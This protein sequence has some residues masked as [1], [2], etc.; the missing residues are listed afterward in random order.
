MYTDPSGLT[1]NNPDM[2]EG[3]LIH[4]MIQDE[5]IIWG[6][7]NGK[8]VGIEVHVQEASK[9]SAK[10]IRLDDGS[11]ILKPN[12]P[13]EPVEYGKVDLVDETALQIYEI[14]PVRSEAYGLGEAKWYLHHIE[15]D[16]AFPIGWELGDQFLKGAPEYMGEWPGYPDYEV[17]AELSTSDG[18]V[19]YWSRKKQEQD[20]FQY[21]LETECISDVEAYLL[22]LAAAGA[23]AAEA[24]RNMRPTPGYGT[25][26]GGFA[27][28]G[29]GA[30]CK[31][32]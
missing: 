31:I 18:V 24:A 10:R 5:F 21:E 15:L 20:D 17:W 28:G 30:L 16:G 19:T 22:W 7:E 14:K 27:G 9:Q 1:P 23:L 8:I 29:C 2:T 6:F 32:Y 25:A 26:G 11:I 4:T 13:S 12:D 3:R